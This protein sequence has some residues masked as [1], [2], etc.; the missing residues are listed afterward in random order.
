MPIPFPADLPDPGTELGSPA[1][2][3]DS[4]PTELSGKPRT[5]IATL[6]NQVSLF[7]GVNHMLFIHLFI[8]QTFIGCIQC[9][10]GSILGAGDTEIDK[11][12]EPS[13]LYS[14]GGAHTIRKQ[15]NNLYWEVI[16]L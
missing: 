12:D 8:Q 16:F 5:L 6:V 7:T 4:L 15:I 13:T 14:S 10:I 2:Q 1:L 9:Q 11:A 3:E